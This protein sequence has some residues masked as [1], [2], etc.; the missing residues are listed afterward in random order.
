VNRLLILSGG[1]VNEPFIAGAA[2]VG[3]NPMATLMIS[4][5]ERFR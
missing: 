4:Y 2:R 3:V 5:G 1:M